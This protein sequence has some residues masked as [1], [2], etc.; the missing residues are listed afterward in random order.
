MNYGSSVDKPGKAEHSQEQ[1]HMGRKDF[2]DEKQSI[3][4]DDTESQYVAAP[5]R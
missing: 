4:S 3:E 1:Q 2:T 5:K